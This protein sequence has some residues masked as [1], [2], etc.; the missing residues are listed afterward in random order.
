M[1]E[2]SKCTKKCDFVEKSLKNVNYYK[3]NLRVSKLFTTFAR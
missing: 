2:K 3:K 1:T